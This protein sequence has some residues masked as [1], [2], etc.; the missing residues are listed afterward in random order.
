[1]A[2]LA[3]LKSFLPKRKLVDAHYIILQAILRAVFQKKYQNPLELWNSKFMALWPLPTK[4][5]S[6]IYHFEAGRQWGGAQFFVVVFLPLFFIVPE[7]DHWE[8]LSVT[9]SLTH[10]L[11]FSKLDWCDSYDLFCCWCLVVA[12]KLILGLDS[13]LVWSRFLSLSFVEMVMFGWDFE[14]DARS[15]FWRCLIKICVWTCDMT[16]RS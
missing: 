2:F 11:L 13:G 7:S 5:R 1:M 16:Q 14:V 15:R 4:L 6:M 3:I 9:D 10:S 8:C 12:K